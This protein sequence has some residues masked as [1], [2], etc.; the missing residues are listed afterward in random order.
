[1]TVE[2][3]AH[4]RL[5]RFAPLSGVA[6]A[7]VTVVAFVVIGGGS[8][9]PKATDSAAKI[10]AYYVTHHSKAEV[11]AYL[12][13]VVAALLAM[14]VASCVPLIR[15]VRSVWAALFYGGGLLAG[16]GFLFAG[17]IHLALADGANHHLDPAVLQGLNAVDIHTALAFTAGVGILLLGGGGAMTALSGGMRVMGWIALALGLINLTPAGVALFPLNALWIVAVSVL[18]CLRSA[19]PGAHTPIANVAD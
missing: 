12:L 10:T 4:S 2:P 9:T 7:V 16:A 14:F 3:S 11:A 19:T 6:F 5:E 1:M 17:A 18:L 15:G 8:R 13:P